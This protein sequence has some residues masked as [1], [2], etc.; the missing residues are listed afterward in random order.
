MAHVVQNES[1]MGDCSPGGEAASPWKFLGPWVLHPRGKVPETE[2]SFVN[3]LVSF[4]G[5]PGLLCGPCS[6][7]LFP[8]CT[9]VEL[10]VTMSVVEGR[11]WSTW[12]GS[13]SAG[14]P[15]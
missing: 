2:T 10:V 1:H 9:S 11:S 13:R 15:P 5:L 6:L 4:C 12:T 3:D 7:D 14:S 8:S